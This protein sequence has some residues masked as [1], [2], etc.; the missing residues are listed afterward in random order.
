MTVTTKVIDLKDTEY[1]SSQQWA[2][3][4]NGVYMNMLAGV[5]YDEITGKYR[6]APIKYSDANLEGE[7][8]RFSNNIEL[9]VVYSCLAKDYKNNKSVYNEWWEHAKKLVQMYK[10]QKQI[11]AHVK[12]NNVDLKKLRDEGELEDAE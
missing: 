6:I 12:S 8:I 2:E 5:R 11:E 7:K 9:Q 1:R 4:T 3:S 10:D